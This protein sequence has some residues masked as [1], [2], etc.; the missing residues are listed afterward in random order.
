MHFQLWP[1]LTLCLRPHAYHGSKPLSIA[2]RNAE[3]EKNSDFGFRCEHAMRT[4]CRA[5]LL[6]NDRE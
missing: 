4:V 6:G 1:Q 3:A 2:K 5:L